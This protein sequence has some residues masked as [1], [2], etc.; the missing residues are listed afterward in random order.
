[1]LSGL[2][3]RFRDTGILTSGALLAQGINL[4][5]APVLSR[6]YTPIDFGVFALFMTIVTPLAAVASLKYD[7][8]IYLP[9]ERAEALGVLHIALLV[10]A[11]L[12]AVILTVSVAIDRSALSGLHLDG[13][14][15]YRYLIG[16]SVTL[17]G[18]Y[19]SLASWAARSHRFGLLARTRVTQ[20]VSNA[21]IGVGFGV[22]ESG[23]LGLVLGNMAYLG[24]GSVALLKTVGAA[25]R[26]ERPVGWADITARARKYWRFPA[27]T[28]PQALFTVAAFQ[29]PPVV[30]NWFYG[31][32]VTG[33]YGLAVRLLFLPTSVLGA[34]ITQ[35]EYVHAASLRSDPER[36]RAATWQLSTYLI[37]FTVVAFS[38]LAV[39]APLLFP[40]IL[41]AQWR[42]AGVFAA[43]LA[44]WLGTMLLTTSLSYL[45]LVADRQRAASLISLA[46]LV[47]RLGALAVFARWVSATMAVAILSFTSAAFGAGVTV[48]YLRLAGVAIGG[49]AR[50][51][52][53]LVFLPSVPLAF[54][55][56]AAADKSQW[57]RV[58][59]LSTAILASAALATLGARS[60]APLPAPDA[61]TT[62]KPEQAE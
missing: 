60:L 55:A 23:P 59:L 54:G 41:G 39:V 37:A 10:S 49:I 52:A 12:G 29:A 2:R 14:W 25:H 4:A 50:Q 33:Y 20:G 32:S 27:F 34:S 35:T 46:E 11:V 30:L 15:A 38:G 19:S 43:L 16:P 8:A 61:V 1:M 28:A 42:T 51:L 5:I 53:L 40:L 13:I 26:R 58:C 24:G 47:L 22:L 17:A 45:P 3:R 57:L 21:A 44:P 56:L 48:W 18:V 9:E 36:L 31:A 62:P 6:L 7:A